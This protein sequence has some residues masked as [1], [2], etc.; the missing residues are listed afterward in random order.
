VIHLY[1]VA[2]TSDLP[3]PTDRTRSRYQ[4]P[5]SFWIVREQRRYEFMA[6]KLREA[7]SDRYAELCDNWAEQARLEVAKLAEV[8]E[9]IAA[10]DARLKG[11]AA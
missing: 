8:E 9:R 5:E 6:A 10:L 7:G 2:N 11:G 1:H 3:T 4:V